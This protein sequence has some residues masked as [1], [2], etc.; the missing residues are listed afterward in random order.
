MLLINWGREISRI[1]PNVLETMQL[2]ISV[3]AVQN[4]NHQ[5]VMDNVVSR[6]LS[7]VTRC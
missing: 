7:D 5:G 3:Q 2:T 6:S 1:V 4:F